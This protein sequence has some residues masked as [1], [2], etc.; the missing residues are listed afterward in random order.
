MTRCGRDAGAAETDA[1]AIAVTMA[2]A[3]REPSEMNP[4]PIDN[5]LSRRRP[6]QRPIRAGYA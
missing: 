4:L 1:V 6:W 5:L 2:R 3:V